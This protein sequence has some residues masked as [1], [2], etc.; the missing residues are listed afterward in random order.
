MEVKVG[1]IA[2]CLDAAD[3]ST[4]LQPRKANKNQSRRVT[5]ASVVGNV[6]EWYDFGVF[7]FLAP[8]IGPCCAYT[9]QL[10]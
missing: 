5:L 4:V 8:Q 10:S 9:E 1:F 7:A 3:P 6:L 2:V